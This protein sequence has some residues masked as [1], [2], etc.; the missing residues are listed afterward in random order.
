MKIT[1]IGCGNMGKGLAQRLSTDQTL[2]FYD[3]YFE[4]AQ[5]LQDQR[6][7]IACQ[8]VQE[9]LS[10]S[11]IIILAVKPQDLAETAHLIRSI[12]PQH[13][14]I[15]ILAG[16][17]I[18]RIKQY[19]PNN[20]IIRMMPN[21][22]MIY[23][24]GLIG[25][26]TDS[27]PAKE[28]EELFSELCK[29]L[30]KAYWIKEKDINAFTSLASSGP[31]FVLTLIEAMIDAGIGMGFTAGTAQEFVLQMIKGSLHLL[32]KSAKH[33]GELKWQIASPEGT[34]IAGLI[35]LEELGLRGSVIDTFLAAY[36]RANEL[37]SE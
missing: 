30:G 27:P 10:N 32:E 11:A 19:F 6:Y 13:I 26:T 33:P 20:Q 23:G 4:K 1:I 17:P 25:L 16:T 7:G 14:I 34:T 8:D 3:K 28:T 2:Y 22:A 31:A 18:S 5:D 35:K 24:E 9:C 12:L 15:S 36:K 37:S 21:L 29:P